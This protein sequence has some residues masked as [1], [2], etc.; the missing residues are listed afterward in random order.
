M[1]TLEETPTYNLGVVVQETGINP[2]TLRAWERRYGLPNPGRTEGGHRLY[3]R[4]DIRTVKWLLARQDEGMRIGQAVD[5]WNEL[6]SAGRD[7]F[8]EMPLQ[9]E[10]GAGGTL[11]LERARGAEDVEV[12]ET[13]RQAWLRAGMAF[14]ETRADEIFTDALARF[15]VEIATYQIL[16]KGMRTVGDKWIRGEISVQTEHFISSLAEKRVQALMA[17]LPPAVREHKL[18]IACSPGERHTFSSLLVALFLRRR[19]YPV[20][21]LGAE[22]PYRDLEDMLRSTS[23][24][25]VILSAQMLTSAGRLYPVVEDLVSHG[26]PVGYGGR[27]FIQYPSLRE[28]LSGHYLGDDLRDI[29]VR[30]AEVFRKPGLALQRGV[31]IPQ[32]YSTLLEAYQE[33]EA[34]I[35]VAVQTSLEDRT[36]EGE[37]FSIA[38]RHLTEGIQASLKLGDLGYLSQQISWINDLLVNRDISP[39]VLSSFLEQFGKQ[40]AQVLGPQGEELAN[41]LI[42]QSHPNS[43]E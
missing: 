5:L 22:V 12:L 2:D 19:G 10:R 3:S 8:Q 7:P 41:W 9:E 18:V 32:R 20:L 13:L 40:T 38:T 35:F 39:G 17:G 29:A 25:L 27:I 6:R 28:V 43:K 42:N 23:A 1:N 16:L 33:A 36:L 4:E 15:P 24:D 14:D 34:R 26:I 11:A 30:V 21:Y 31:E 37:Y